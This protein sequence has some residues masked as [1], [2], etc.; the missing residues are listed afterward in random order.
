MSQ[1]KLKDQLHK[2]DGK[3]TLHSN[4]SQFKPYSAKLTF[5]R[6]QALHSNMS[7]FKLRFLCDLHFPCFSLHSNM[8]QFKQ[9]GR[10]V[11]MA[12]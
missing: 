12:G 8:S 4:M 1:F 2:A 10:S 3:I 7:Q 11:A 5:L 9:H 6:T